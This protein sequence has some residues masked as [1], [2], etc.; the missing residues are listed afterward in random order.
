M[1]QRQPH[2]REP[3]AEEP[4]KHEDEDTPVH[5]LGWSGLL[6]RIDI[7]R[8]C[9]LHKERIK[10]VPGVGDRNADWMF[11]GEAPGAEE[12]LT[13]EPFVGPAGRLLDTLLAAMG[14][15]RTSVYICNVV[16]CRPPKNR[17]PE[18]REC[19]ACMPYLRRQIELVAPKLIVAL[20]KVAA[21]NLLGTDLGVGRLRGD[22][23][24]HNGIPVAVTYHPSYLLRSPGNRKLVWTDLCDAMRH[25]QRIQEEAESV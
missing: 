8:L 21:E 13:G 2:A 18:E 14:Q 25:M 20:G 11:V 15:S 19:E 12:N 9:D 1:P 22:L 4:E 24:D 5:E 3:A 7:C 10:S 23:H 16:K 17:N 6:S